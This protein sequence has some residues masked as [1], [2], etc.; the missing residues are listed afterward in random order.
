MGPIGAFYFTEASSRHGPDEVLEETLE[1][2]SHGR[3]LR[4]DP[5]TGTVSR[6]LE[7]LHFANGVA[8]AP[9]EAYLLVAET[10]AFRVTRYRLARAGAQR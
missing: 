7:G 4:Y 8:V 2:G 5:A 1:R 3:L 10:S 6:L 9:D